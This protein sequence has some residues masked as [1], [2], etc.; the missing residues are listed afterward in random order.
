MNTVYEQFEKFAAMQAE[1][2]EPFK[3]IGGVA[4]ETFAQFSRQNYAVLGDYVEFAVDQAKL[5]TQ[6]ADPKDYLGKQL[7]ATRAFGEKL[8]VRA[9]EYA[10]IVRTAQD[11]AQDV[12]TKTTKSVAKKAA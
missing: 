4:A 2:I 12:A 11:Q 9:Q 3:A 5:P 7:E 8:A 6:A 10:T 1:A